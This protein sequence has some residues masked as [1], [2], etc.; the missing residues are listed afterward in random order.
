MATQRVKIILPM[1]RL[2]GITEAA[3]ARF[4]IGGIES[5]FATKCSSAAPSDAFPWLSIGID[6]IQFHAGGFPKGIRIAAEESQPHSQSL[7]GVWQLV[8]ANPFH[9]C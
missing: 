4:G 5:E 2:A 7:Q 1:R 6:Q 9:T 8:I 3:L